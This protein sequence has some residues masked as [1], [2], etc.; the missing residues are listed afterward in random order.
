ME[1]QAKTESWGSPECETDPL[2]SRAQTSV[3]KGPYNAGFV[4]AGFC[5]APGYNL[6]V[7]VAGLA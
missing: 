7:K 5:E 1:A 6:W 4:Q 2:R 3:N